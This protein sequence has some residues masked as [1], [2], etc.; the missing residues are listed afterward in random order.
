MRN[1]VSKMKALPTLG[2]IACLAACGSSEPDSTASTVIVQGTKIA[3]NWDR[4]TA[5][6]ATAVG[7]ITSDE[8]VLLAARAIEKVTGC[9]AQADEAT[10]GQSVFIRSDGQLELT[11]GIDCTLVAA[12]AQ[13]TAP[14]PSRAEAV[15]DTQRM[16]A[17]VEKALRQ[18]AAEPSSRPVT[19]AVAKPTRQ[20]TVPAPASR[21]P[22]L[23]YEGSPYAAFT[24]AEIQAYCGQG[25]TTR[26]AAN[27]RTEYNPCTQRSAFR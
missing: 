7:T 16:A 14:A 21:T 17:A 2:L 23:L 1:T 19:Q 11:L 18:V 25:W 27:G 20:A 24:A 12:T 15:A 10:L 26:V 6:Q 9:T 4:A 5:R 22:A 13:N 3:V 8:P